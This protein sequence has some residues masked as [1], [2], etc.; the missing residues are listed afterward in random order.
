[1]LRRFIP[2]ILPI[3]GLCSMPLTSL[4]A[5]MHAKG[6][7]LRLTHSGN[8]VARYP[9]LSR[10]GKKM[11]Y[12]LES[13]ESE[14]NA[15][16]IRIMDI[17]NCTETELFRD[18][19]QRAPGPYGDSYLIVGSK[20]PVLS[21]NG[22]VAAFTLSI[23][24]PHHLQDHF[25]AVVSTDGSQF[26]KTSFPIQNLKGV[27]L[28]SHEFKSGNW[29]RVA[30]F[31]LSA[32][33]NRILCLVKGHLGPRRFGSASGIIC[34]DVAS[35]KQISLLAP[36]FTDNGWAWTSFPR[37]PSTG[38]GWAFCMSEDG[39]TIV[40]GAQTSDDLNDYDLYL[41]EW[42]GREMERLTDFHDRRFSLA[43]I[44]Q[45]GQTILFFYNGRK[46]QGIGTYRIG[47]DGSDLTFLE[48]RSAPRID[49]FGL[50]RDGRFVL[51]KHIYQGQRMDLRTGEE[52]VAFSDET[53][54]YVQGITPMDFP[55]FPSFWKPQIVSA[56]GDRVLL[57]G[58]PIGKDSPE[59]YLLT[60]D[61]E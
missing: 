18:G 55:H 58:P 4:S 14:G 39:K 31:A 12:T 20:P 29:E 52:I 24:A 33:G 53:E 7:I 8:N 49:F 23:E 28:K 54:G 17:E 6:H 60:L 59:I 11:L 50:S 45:N 30:N 26:W 9:C 16:A 38:G 21:G 22:K 27:D 1:M 19:T 44:S 3:I 48:S 42:M 57:V 34:L 37:R 25:L 5:E 46:K 41:A 40:F 61:R 2:I 15:K 43:D 47:R 35:E 13:K 51:F 32:D 56:S 10:D 36:E